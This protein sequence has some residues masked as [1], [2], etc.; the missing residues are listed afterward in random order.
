[1]GQAPNRVAVVPGDPRSG[2]ICGDASTAGGGTVVR[3]CCFGR[4]FDADNETSS[5]SGP[6]STGATGDVTA[7]QR[8][9]GRGAEINNDPKPPRTAT[10]PSGAGYVPD[11]VFDTGSTLTS[12]FSSAE[13]THTAS[14]LTPI[15]PSK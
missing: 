11:T 3:R 7:I 5:D 15:E 2:V 6:Y 14:A 8:V 12:V 4:R 1:M 9:V 10:A 13:I